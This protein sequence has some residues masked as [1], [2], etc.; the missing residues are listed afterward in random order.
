MTVCPAL[1]PGL[2]AAVPEVGVGGARCSTLEFYIQRHG[3]APLP[4]HVTQGTTDMTNW[5]LN[6]ELVGQSDSRAPTQGLPA[7][8]WSSL[9]FGHV[10]FLIRLIHKELSCPGSATGDQVP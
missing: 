6:A 7:I 2:Q 5:N 8:M 1:R 3:A 4:H 10:Q 9:C